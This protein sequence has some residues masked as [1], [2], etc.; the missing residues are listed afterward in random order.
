MNF[1]QESQLLMKPFLKDFEKYHKEDTPIQ[2]NKK[3]TVFK[4][5]LRDINI[6]TKYIEKTKDLNKIIVK[7]ILT[8]KDLPPCTLLDNKYIPQYIS[9][10]ISTNSFGYMKLSTMISGIKINIYFMFFKK[11]D[12]NHLKNIEENLFYTLRV[13]KFFTFYLRNS[14]VKDF[15]IFLFLTKFKKTLP[16][17]QITTLSQENCNSAVT[18]ACATKGELLLYREEEWKKVLIH[19]LMHSLCLDFS[20][21]NYST[22]KSR[23]KTIYNIKSDFLISESYCEYWATILNCAFISHEFLQDK[24]DTEKFLLYLQFCIQME[25]IFSLFQCVKVLNYMSLVYENLFKDDSISVTFRSILYKENTNVF[26]YYILK[27]ILLYFNTEFILCCSLNNTN[28]I[29]FDK[30]PQNLKKMGDFFEKYYKDN[31]LLKKINIM[32]TYYKKVN[33]TYIKPS[34]EKLNTT[35]RMTVCDIE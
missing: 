12:F 5:L 30:T 11:S 14:K 27:L 34:K 10:Y 22:L 23:V 26:S 25:T 3:D 21:I 19:E 13:I 9:N 24:H 35:M 16:K 7:E 29:Y 28:T 20:G 31:D 15:D 4:K 18:Y 32:E 2:Q 17:S 33:G 8:K 6:A 1:S